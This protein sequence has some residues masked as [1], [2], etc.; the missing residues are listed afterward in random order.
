MTQL[1]PF[2]VTPSH[3]RQNIIKTHK[4]K[5]KRKRKKREG[6]ERECIIDR[7]TKRTVLCVL[8]CQGKRAKKEEKERFATP[9]SHFSPSTPRERREERESQST[10]LSLFRLVMVESKANIFHAFTGDSQ[11]SILL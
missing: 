8:F 5:Q 2:P 7:A 9:K 3:P 4:K 10:S 1:C 11:T 6:G